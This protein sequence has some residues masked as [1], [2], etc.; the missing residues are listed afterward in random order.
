LE[1]YFIGLIGIVVL[2]ILFFLKVPIGFSMLVVGTAG[3]CYII[4]PKAGLSL[5]GSDLFFQFSDYSLSAFPMF[6]LAGS[7]AFASGMGDRIFAATH[8]LFGR[9]PGNLAVASAAACA[10][11]AAIC[12]SSTATTAAVGKVALPAMR[13]ANYDTALATGVIASAGGL[14]FY[15]LRAADRRV[16][17]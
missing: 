6:I 3:F 11:F 5:L 16:H 8:S 10:G 17:R 1:N 9:L 13:K 7:L 12:G 4:S 15:P 2:V 14:D